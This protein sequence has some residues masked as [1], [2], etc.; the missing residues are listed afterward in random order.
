MSTGEQGRTMETGRVSAATIDAAGWGMFFIWVGVALVASVGWG[1]GLL[2]TG[3]ISLGVQL[4][5]SL[6]A[7]KVDRWGLAFGT[8]LI[9]AG[10]VQ[11]L[12]IPLHNAPLPSWLV[13]AA[14]IALGV[15][16]LASTWA[17]RHRG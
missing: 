1:V 11:W 7:L 2:G 8:C 14:F 5:R 17:R 6:V 12:D 3:I 9:V 4:A 16:I 13:A 15:A 10:L